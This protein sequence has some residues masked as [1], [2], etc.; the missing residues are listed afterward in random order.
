MVLTLLISKVQKGKSLER[1]ESISAYGKSR[2]VRKV[3]NSF[4]YEVT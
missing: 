3:R 2:E 1:V 4:F